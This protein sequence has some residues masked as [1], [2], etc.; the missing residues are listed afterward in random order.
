[1]SICHLHQLCWGLHPTL[2]YTNTRCTRREPS[3]QA[4]HTMN[5]KKITTNK[6]DGR[7]SNSS[8]SKWEGHQMPKPQ[9]KIQR[10]GKQISPDKKELYQFT[11]GRVALTLTANKSNIIKA[12]CAG[13]TIASW[14]KKDTK[15]RREGCS[16]PHRKPSKITI[17]TWWS[18]VTFRSWHKQDTHYWWEGCSDLHRKPKAWWWVGATI[19]SQHQKVTRNTTQNKIKKRAVVILS[20]YG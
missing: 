19:T 13:E 4:Q 18:G 20:F 10:W 8:S 9:N 2:H 15:Y 1:M 17:K 7:P 16:D 11:G 5:N 12:R 3:H 14:H 6:G